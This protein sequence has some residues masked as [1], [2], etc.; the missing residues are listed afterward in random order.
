MIPMGQRCRTSLV[1]PNDMKLHVIMMK[2]DG[3]VHVSYVSED[4]CR[5]F[6]V[7]TL[8]IVNKFLSIGGYVYRMII[9]FFFLTVLS[10]FDFQ[11]P[12]KRKYSS[13]VIL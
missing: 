9:L 2:P 4:Q 13:C 3:R 11:V 6:S 10:E 12:T 5:I 1:C 7:C 8:F